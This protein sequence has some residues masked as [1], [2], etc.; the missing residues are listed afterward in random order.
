MNSRIQRRANNEDSRE[1]AHILVERITGAIEAKHKGAFPLGTI[2]RIRDPSALVLIS[3]LASGTSVW[4]GMDDASTDI[5]GGRTDRRG[6]HVGE[7]GRG[8]RGVRE[9]GLLLRHRAE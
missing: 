3:R 2:F 4:I 1:L 5:E 7:R 8:S 6:G 9:Q